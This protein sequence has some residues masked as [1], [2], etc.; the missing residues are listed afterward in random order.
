MKKILLINNYD[1]A[2]TRKAYLAGKSPSYHQFGTSELIESGEYIVDYLLVAPKNFNSRIFK[3]LSL[4][5]VWFKAYRKAVKYDY[6]Y[7]AADFTV[8][9]MGMMKKIGLFKPKLLTIF[10]HPPFDLRLKVA[11][12]DSIIFLS[13]F[14]NKEM[15]DKF[16]KLKKKMSF[17]QWGPDIKF[18]HTYSPIHNYERVHDKIVFVSNGKTHR[19]HETLLSA[20][21]KSK[22]HAVIVCDDKSLP[23]NYNSETCSYTEI[24]YQNKPDDIKM[25]QLLCRSSVLVV[26][27]YPGN[28]TLGPIGLTS[29][30]DSVAIGMPVI[31]A[32]NTI[33]SDIVER[34]KI[35]FVYKAGDV[36]DL[37]EKMN[38]F[39]ENQELIAIYGKNATEFGLRND[40]IKFG[41]QLK[42]LI[43][44]L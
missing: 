44:K 22:N 40:I 18:Y 19:D 3:M 10:H 39:T 13:E 15:S 24:F 11:K 30:L 23:H 25:I 42:L 12:Y 31:T 1:M 41:N 29:F 5:P 7:G 32:N 36:D 2:K 35:G 4:I 37:C 14:A 9:F 16:P 6:V 26:P 43:E 20:A 28:R 17:L 33:L 21:E 38:R 34:E 8:D 27:T